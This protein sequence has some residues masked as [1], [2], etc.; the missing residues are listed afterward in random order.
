MIGSR[1]R[2]IVGL[3][4]AQLLYDRRR[5]II[6]VL[7]ITVAV[8][9]TTLLASVGFGVV[10]FG[11]QKFD[12]AGRD[13][14]ISGGPSEFQPGSVG[15]IENTLVGAHT[16]E[17]QLEARDDVETANPLIF[18]TAYASPNTSSFETIAVVG[19]AS[20]GPAV[21]VIEGRS[22]RMSDHYANGTYDGPMTHEIVID[23]RTASL[24]DVSV[25]DTL[26]VGGTLVTARQHNFTV[27][28]ISNTFSQ[29][30]GAP[31][32]VMPP[33]E[34]Q[35]I[36][37]TTGSDRATFISVQVADGYTTDEAA[38]Q[39]AADYPE[40]EIRTNQEQ[41]GA[42]LGEKAVVIASG[43]SLIG[44]AVIAGVALTL[45]LQLSLIFQQKQTFGA[46]QAIGVSARTLVGTVVV[47]SLL[48][49]VLGGLFGVVLTI[50]GVWAANRVASLVTGFEGLASLSTTVLAGGFVIAVSI[51]LLGALGSGIYLSRHSTVSQLRP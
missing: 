13:L 29:F 39:I 26:Y 19:A 36:T 31:T 10:D 30:V 34:L 20:S 23:E 17:H 47:R 12:S 14:W 22:T 41:I 27:V 1:L 37:G 50:P 38:R 21:T 4:V 25:N 33:S 49:S 51:G 35:E 15:G 24:Y 11:Q 43:I 8:L 46:A 32:I 5:T 9:G 48:L 2:A 40:Y 3:A 28:G 16:V 18:Q 45:N 7:G 6:A 44:L 42:L